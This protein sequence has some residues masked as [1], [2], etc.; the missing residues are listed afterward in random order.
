MKAH[1]CQSF[2]GGLPKAVLAA[3]LEE[4]VEVSLKAETCPSEHW[5]EGAVLAPDCVMVQES[6]P[7]LGQSLLLGVTAPLPPSC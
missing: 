2:W 7:K 4:L 1:K 3:A 6:S 5:V